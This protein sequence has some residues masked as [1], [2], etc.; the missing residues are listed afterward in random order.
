MTDDDITVNNEMASP[1]DILKSPEVTVGEWV[2]RS[3]I[4]ASRTR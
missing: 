1:L 2:T 3:V 4:N